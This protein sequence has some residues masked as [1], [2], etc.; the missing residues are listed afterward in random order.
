MRRRFDENAN[1]LA[2]S[3]DGHFGALTKHFLTRLKE[4][5]WLK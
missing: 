2:E 4:A 5:T 1:F 3:K